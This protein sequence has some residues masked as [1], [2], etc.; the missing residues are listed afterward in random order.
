MLHRFLL[1]VLLGI[2]VLT[3]T[4]C[5]HAIFSGDPLRRNHQLLNAS[6]GLRLIH[7]EWERFWMLDQPSHLTP[8]RTHGGII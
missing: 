3:S 5:V 1:S 7:D 4:G 2:A 6:E 8:Y